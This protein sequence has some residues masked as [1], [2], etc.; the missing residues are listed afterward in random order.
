MIVN[1][2]LTTLCGELKRVCF[3]RG[4]ED[5]LTAVVVRVG[6]PI[7]MSQRAEELERTISPDT[8]F[9]VAASEAHAALGPA[10]GGFVP[11]SRIAFPGKDQSADAPFIDTLEPENS[12]VIERRLDVP[13]LPPRKSGIERTMTRLFLFVIVLGALAAAFYG[14]RRYKGPIPYLDQGASPA[15]EAS[16]TPVV[17]D[18]PI[19]KFERGRREVDNDP[20]AWLSTRLS[21]ELLRQGLQNPL[22]S[23]EAE[24]LYLYGRASLLTGNNDEA[25]KAFEAA[26]ARANLVSPQGNATLKKEAALGLA[27][28]GIKSDKDRLA[29]QTRFDEV[30]RQSPSP[31][32]APSSSP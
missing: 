19:L 15:A 1:D 10:P 17:G 18:D 28:V 21:S 16:P 3:E 5:N 13:I 4:A 24:F 29:V 7:S 9:P 14:G 27:A 6:A 32:P 20:N 2:D 11:A 31:S 23:T 26:I 22:D 12:N 8:P 30:M 25:L